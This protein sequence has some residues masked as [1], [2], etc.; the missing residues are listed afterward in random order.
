[1][2]NLVYQFSKMFFYGFT[3]LFFFVLLFSSLSFLEDILGW[4]V[5][6]VNIKTY[7]G[8]K[9]A[10]IRVPI[11]EISFVFPIKTIFPAI[12]MSLSLLYYVV[13]FY[14]LRNFFKIFIKENLFSKESLKQLKLFRK[15]NLIAVLIT[16]TLILI[17]TIKKRSFQFDEEVLVFTI[18][19]FIAFL[20]YFFVELIKRGNILQQE[21]DL[22][23]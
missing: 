18:H 19:F 13:F 12:I 8:F 14:A 15:V 11:L 20:I 4:N 9:Q 21:N 7:E 6:F 16:I 17:T 2:K 3:F 5:P 1:M 10:F 23:I 22:T